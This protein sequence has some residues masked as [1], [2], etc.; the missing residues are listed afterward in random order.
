[1]RLERAVAGEVA[2]L[3]RRNSDAKEVKRALKG[4]GSKAAVLRLDAVRG[5][6]F[7]GVV[8]YDASEAAYAPRHP[9]NA[10]GL[11]LAVSRALHALAFVSMGKPTKL[12]DGIPHELLHRI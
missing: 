6:E 5:R 12:L 7:A 9:I 2:V 11:Y 10:R 1:L 4:M 8:I 3:V